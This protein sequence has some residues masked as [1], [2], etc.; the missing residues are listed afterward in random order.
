M[1]DNVLDVFNREFKN[2][3]L[4]NHLMNELLL[5]CCSPHRHVDNR[6]LFSDAMERIDNGLFV[7]CHN[8]VNAQ[9]TK[10]LKIIEL[11]IAKLLCID[12]QNPQFWGC[13]FGN[14]N[15]SHYKLGR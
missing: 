8:F 1:V 15:N 14:S 4:L 11:K 5:Y 10:E 13:M 7:L 12:Q 9:I 6:T 3:K 2:K